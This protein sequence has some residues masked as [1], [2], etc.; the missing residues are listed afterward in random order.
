MTLKSRITALLSWMD[1]KDYPQHELLIQAPTLL[2]EALAEI[3]RLEGAR[4]EVRSI[5]QSAH[6]ALR[7]CLEVVE[8]WRENPLGEIREIIEAALEGKS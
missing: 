4:D 2:T 8:V 3:E 7:K 1:S 6:G 5:A